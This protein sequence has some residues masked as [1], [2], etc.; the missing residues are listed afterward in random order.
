MIETAHQDVS[1]GIG[2]GYLY[3]CTV[4]TDWVAT[5]FVDPASSSMPV[6]IVLKDEEDLAGGPD[7]TADISPG[8]TDGLFIH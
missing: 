7:G 4:S 2:T 5:G 6:I 3:Q 8:A 1:G